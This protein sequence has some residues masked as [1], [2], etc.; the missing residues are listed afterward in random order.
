MG[1]AKR[2]PSLAGAGGLV[3]L[4]GAYAASR[5]LTRATCVGCH[6]P[7]L[8]ASK[9]RR[10]S[11]SAAARTDNADTLSNTQRSSLARSSAAWAFIRSPRRR[12]A[13][14]NY[15]F[16][17]LDGCFT[18]SR[19]GPHWVDAAWRSPAGPDADAHFV[20]DAGRPASALAAESRCS[21]Y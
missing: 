12:E 7:P 14:E 18:R 11:S 21:V 1:P 4:L 9:P 17:A 16:L 13:A 6:R 8:G 15:I 10:V 19:E 20:L 3:T 5:R 2:G